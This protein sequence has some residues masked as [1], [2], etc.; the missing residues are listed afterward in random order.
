MT[1]VGVG[2][3]VKLIL[4]L[5]GAPR[6][7]AIAGVCHPEFVSFID[8]VTAIG[9]TIRD[10]RLSACCTINEILK[11]AAA[12]Q[13]WPRA[14]ASSTGSAVDPFSVMSMLA[15]VATHRALASDMH[16]KDSKDLC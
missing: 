3:G 8:Q 7:G 16:L 9:R 1:Y 6:A 5:A 12:D 10:A 13:A 4:G 15:A 11:A 14:G 2:H